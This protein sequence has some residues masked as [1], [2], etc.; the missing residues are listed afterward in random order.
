MRAL[1]SSLLTACF[2]IA[3]ASV[4]PAQL[5]FDFLPMPCSLQPGD[6][7][8]NAVVILDYD[9]DGLKDVAVGAPGRD[10]VYLYRG[11]A[12]QTLVFERAFRI[13]GPQAL[14]N[15]PCAAVP[16]I[17]RFGASLAAGEYDSAT[18]DALFVGAPAADGGEGAFYVFSSTLTPGVG[19]LPLR[20]T[21]PP[22]QGQNPPNTGK[23]LGTSIA[24][25]HF[26]GDALLD[27]AAG[28]PEAGATCNPSQLVQGRVYLYTNGLG[29]VTVLEN[30]HACVD[31]G[32]GN[33]RFGTPVRAFAL[34][35]GKHEL[36][37]GAEGNP[38]GPVG[39]E[40]ANP[41]CFN[42][43][44]EVIRYPWPVSS[45]TQQLI[46]DPAPDP[47]VQ[48]PRYGKWFDTRGGR[49]VV[50]A[51]RKSDAAPKTGSMYLYTR[52]PL[53]DQYIFSERFLIAP[54]Q[55]QNLDLFASRVALVDLIEDSKRDL[56]SIVWKT[57]EIHIWNG[58]EAYPDPNDPN[59]VSPN[60]TPDDVIQGPAAT[61]P[62][63]CEGLDTGY[64][65]TGGK[66]QMVIGNPQFD[67]LRGRAFVLR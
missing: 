29:T 58:R 25:G 30:P 9:G 13:D 35:T 44:G 50:G 46:H 57:Q 16:E 12:T 1:R 11:T 33:A 65:F 38:A 26:D 23:K 47:T 2:A 14:G 34:A 39:C 21:P 51:N 36:I 7:F 37:V 3:T 27:V 59:Y 24:V 63:W 31:A 62:H 53:T 52:D 5:Y 48:G 54:A 8:G 32:A 28:A 64:L 17:E 56:V 42:K 19:H 43:G 49:L 18:R 55:Q 20:F 61:G 15:F 10:T 45:A 22:Y 66:E 67:G 40:S 41:P 4:A 60:V 6:L